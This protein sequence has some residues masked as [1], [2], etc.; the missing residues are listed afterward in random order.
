MAPWWGKPSSKEVKRKENTDCFINT[1]QRK[2]KSASEEKR[3]DKSRGSSRHLSDT[4]SEKGS[5]SPVP[6]RSP[7]PPTHVFCCQIAERPHAQALPLPGL[8]LPSANH[9][10]SGINVTPKLESTTGSKPSLDFPLPKPGYVLNRGQPTDAEGDVATASVCSDSSVDSDD[11]SNS[12][13]LSP[14][15]SDCENGNRTAM[16]SSFRW[17]YF[18]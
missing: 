8:H 3:N 14:L 1:I 12:H 6:S 11:Q 2:S 16:Q 15:A 7:S 9:A 13:V 18:H 5:I 10:N 17:V 4:I